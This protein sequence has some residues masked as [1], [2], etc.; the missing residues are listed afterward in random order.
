MLDNLLLSTNTT[1]TSVTNL[2]KK[3]SKLRIQVE[4][5]SA[6]LEKIDTK[7]ENILSQAEIYRAKLEREM[8]R[9]VRRLERELAILRN[10]SGGAITP[11]QA[12]ESDLKVAATVGIF[13]TILRHMCAN[14]EDFRLASEA[15]LFPVI[16]ERVMEGTEE[17]YYLEETPVSSILVINRGKEY[18][19]WIRS[20][21]ETHVTDPDTW[22]DAIGQ[23]VDWWRNDALPMLYGARDEQW[24]IDMPLSL[25]EILLWRESPG[26]RPLNFPKIF[27]AYEVYRKH[28]DE[29]Y[30][31]TGLREFEL[32]L[33]SFENEEN[34]QS[35]FGPR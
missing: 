14:A 23:I 8:G 35:R 24:D 4:E 28:K 12:S 3:L 19:A 22:G 6:D 32:K 9:E 18:I 27:D 11:A 29:I 1:R 30:G 34:P 17:A 7:F 16:Y 31:T 13:D 10:A 15:F 5:F 33:F 21:Y 2:K 26:D 20:Q 25:Q